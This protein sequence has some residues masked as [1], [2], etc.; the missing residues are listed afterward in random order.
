MQQC[1]RT[2]I[3]RS[4]SSFATFAVVLGSVV[5]ASLGTAQSSVGS[6]GPSRG[7]RAL[8]PAPEARP[9]RAPSIT[10]DL[11]PQTFAFV[12]QE[13]RFRVTV[14][15][16]DGDDVGLVLLNPPPGI[17]FDAPSRAASPLVVDVS[18][19]IPES[20]GGPQRLVFEARGFAAAPLATRLAV[21]LSIGGANVVQPDWENTFLHVGDVTGDGV[22][23]VVAT[24]SGADLGGS[25]DVGAVYVWAGATTISGAPTA[26][27]STGGLDGDRF[28]STHLRLVDISG[29][30]VLDVVAASPDADT[31][32]LV[33]TGAVVV[34]LGGSAL[35]NA[36]GGTRPAD[37]TLSP[38]TGG[39]GLQ[40]TRSDGQGLHM[41]D[42]TGDGVRDVLA[43]APLADERGVADAG[44]IYVWEGGL[45]SGTPAP[46][47]VLLSSFPMLFDEM[48]NT[49]HGESV[50]FADVTGDGLLDVVANG[51]FALGQ[52]GVACGALYVWKGG[53]LAGQ[54]LPHATLEGTGAFDLLGASRFAAD[55][56]FALLDVTGDGLDDV[57]AF[58]EFANANGVECTGRG[59][60]WEG[61]PALVGQAPPRAELVV[62]GAGSDDSLGTSWI[63]RMA[64]VTGDGIVD[65]LVAGEE[66]DL[67][68]GAIYLW[69]GGAPLT[70]IVAPSAT[71]KA[72]TQLLSFSPGGSAPTLRSHAGVFVRDLDRDGVEDILG[73]A[74][75]AGEA[76]Y[77][78]GGPGLSGLP[79]ADARLFDPLLP[80]AGRANGGVAIGD[81][82]GDGMLD[83][84]FADDRAGST[85]VTE[86]GRL[87]VYSGAQLASV[88]G[89]LAPVSVLEVQAPSAF[90]RLGGMTNARGP[91]VR[92]AD[93]NGDGVLDVLASSEAADAGATDSGAVYAWFGGAG[94]AGLRTESADLSP[95]A[96]GARWTAAQTA[97]PFQLADLDGDGVL[98]VVAASAAQG[99]ARIVRG[100]SGL[101]HGASAWRDT[102]PVGADAPAELL[103]MADVT[104]DGRLD[105]LL[106]DTAADAGRGA[107]F[108]WAAPF[109]ASTRVTLSVPGAFGGDGLGS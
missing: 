9:D 22:L 46:D 69:E 96:S 49:A 88:G 74:F 28:G 71:L 5:F 52:A 13:L 25:V 104:G 94:G 65:L 18:W 105:L 45:L 77:W 61:G 12:R 4:F 99:S 86:C 103:R 102:G 87:A 42:V 107:I 106:V 43:V 21:D 31:H 98:D 89:S 93:V 82:T 38:A 62:P 16:L 2:A 68:A 79:A 29:D 6:G 95:A 83:L 57:V 30:D 15:D 101:G 59:W 100:G 35:G 91:G 48:G 14:E 78:R 84:V 19:R 11:A 64:D 37:A 17:V 50:Q 24:A 20:F 73:L 90:D 44:A 10:T 55:N 56:G 80:Q 66:M 27:L 97:T 47:A 41:V 53:C 3:T 34:W 51:P 7:A 32:G 33:D 92:L 39:A 81:V 109:D 23:D 60:V 67:G 8:A 76:F 1:A 70:G 54:T 85:S 58:S 40:L 63:E 75:S 72:A 36:N 26:V 108:V